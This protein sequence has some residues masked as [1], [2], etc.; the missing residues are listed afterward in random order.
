MLI[1]GNGTVLTFD[2]NSRVISKGGVVIE[3][4]RI[5]AVGDTA[6]LLIKYPKAAFKDVQG[7]IIMPGM[8]NTHMHLYSTFARGMNLKTEQPPKN[9]VEILEKLWWRLDKILNEE[10]IYCSAIYALLDSVKKGTTTIFDHHAS[11]NLIDGSLDII[12]EAVRQT[13]IR[14]NLSYEISDR[15]GHEKALDGIRENERFIKKAQ[16]EGNNCLGGLIG[17]HAS[18][19]LNNE[20]LTEVAA[21][22][23]RLRVPF[24]IHVAEGK[25]DYYESKTRGY[26]GVAERLNRFHILRPGTLAIHGVYLKEEELEVIKEHNSYLIHNPESNMGNAVGTAPIKAAMDKGVIVGLGTDGYTSDMFESIK[27]AN[28]LQK[29]DSGNPQAGWAEVFKIVFKNNCEIASGFFGET[30]GVLQAGVPADVIVVD[31]YPPTP[32]NSENAYFHILFGIS[33][34]MVDTT[35]VGGKILMEDREICGIDYQRITKRVREQA[36]KFWKRF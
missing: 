11:S 3:E 16:Q 19:T 32:I 34:D 17:L 36:E 14:A 13:G 35:I 1:V 18:F 4:E 26:Q 27:V 29:H 5:L 8:I 7:K 10:D 20:T 23:D 25:A 2:K 22:A 31:Y 21:L 30:L 15:D 33:G 28:L 6:K 9:F 24:H 12:T